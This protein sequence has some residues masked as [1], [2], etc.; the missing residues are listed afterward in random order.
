MKGGLGRY[1]PPTRGRGTHVAETEGVRHPARQ[2]IAFFGT[3][4]LAAIGLLGI[5]VLASASSGAVDLGV[6]CPPSPQSDVF[7][8][9]CVS[10]PTGLAFAGSIDATGSAD[11]STD[12]NSATATTG[13]AVA[14]GLD[15]VTGTGSISAN[16]NTAT[17]T[18]GEAVA[19][20]SNE[21]FGTGSIV[22]NGNSAATTTGVAVAGGLNEVFGSGSVTAN[23]NSAIAVDG[24]TALAGSQN[25]VASG[26][27]VMT[28]NVA[29][30]NGATAGAYAASNGTGGGSDDI[31]IATAD[32]TSSATAVAGGDLPLV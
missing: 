16:G 10:S 26:N 20:G 8:N 9:V 1:S 17:T 4:F 28:N 12:D 18:I 22:A 14:G 19:G 6:R 23:G 3:G 7:G 15:F 25:T 21:V 13:Q 29:K 11:V 31:A 32:T 24:G 5:Q 2:T 27:V 30:A